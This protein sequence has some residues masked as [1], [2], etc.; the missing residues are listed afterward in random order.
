VGHD[1]DAAVAAATVADE[2]RSALLADLLGQVA[3]CFPRR[4]LSAQGLR[5]HR[6]NKRFTTRRGRPRKIPL[7]C[8]ENLE[9]DFV[10]ALRNYRKFKVQVSEKTIPDSLVWKTAQVNHFVVV[11]ADQDFWNDRQYPLRTSP[12][13]LL[14]DRRNGK[15]RLRAL[16]RIMKA[17]ELPETYLLN[18]DLFFASKVR[19]SAGGGIYKFLSRDGR[20][21]QQS[22]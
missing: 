20:I 3:G 8:D 2:A 22:F 7:L 13:L 9:D 10:T 14:L 5:L 19:A 21:V 18:P 15:E 12:G 6:D 16:A 4:E 11:T 1:Q 17:L